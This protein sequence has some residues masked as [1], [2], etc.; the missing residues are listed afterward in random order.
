MLS[1]YDQGRK[2]MTVSELDLQALTTTAFELKTRQGAHKWTRGDLYI[3]VVKDHIQVVN[4]LGLEDYVSG[5]LEGELGSLRL[6]PEVL[7]AQVIVARSYVLSMRGERHHGRRGLNFVIIRI[8]RFTVESP[9]ITRLLMKLFAPCA[10]RYLSYKKD[11]ADR[12]FFII[13]AAAA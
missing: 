1:V 10:G 3:G 2:K 7:K 11:K 13:T 4:R 5:I 6:S 9:C 12:C 8:V